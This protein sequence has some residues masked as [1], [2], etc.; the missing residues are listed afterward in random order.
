MRFL[1]G[2]VILA[3]LLASR[4][5]AAQQPPAAPTTIAVGDWQLAPTM[6]VRVRGEYR[7]DAPDLGGL[8]MYGRATP[9]TRDAWVVLERT[10]VGLGAERGALRAQVTLQD[11]R[12]FGSPSPNATLAGARGLG[13]LAPYEGFL[14]MRTSG[15]R[16]TYLRLGRQAVVWGEGRL[17]G[18]ADFSPV[19]RSL[20]AARA[21]VAAGNFDFEALAAILEIP[22]PLG[23]AFGDRSGS[24]T[25]G[26]QLYGVTVKWT[27]DPLFRVEAFGLARV[28]RSSGAE[29]DGSR[30][31]IQRAVGER[32]T[33]A[34]RVSGDDKGWSYGAEGAYQMGNA[35]TLR[36][37]GA[38]IAAWAAAAHVQ[39]TLE[40]IVLTP[41][42]R[43]NGS[44]ASGDD[45]SGK[46]TQFD[47]LLADPQRFH[48][49][50]DLF[51]WSN[52]FDLGGRA[53]VVPWTDTALS[54][55][56][57]YA[58][59]AKS[60][61]EW[62]GSYLTA[63]GSATRPPVVAI[64]PAPAGANVDPSLGHELDVGFSWRPWMP[65]EL[66]AS[67]SGLLLGDGAK[68][69]MASHQRGS[70]NLAQYAFL[71]ATLNVP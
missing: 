34:L 61:G 23:A 52:M 60:R 38:D 5:A 70:H 43:L 19:G 4:T 67:W 47:P 9:R 33:G 36:F 3:G 46:Y 44:Y 71:Q 37:N 50:M 48:G 6:E 66:R 54:F 2:S 40:Q 1:A 10:R 20:D 15:V 26:V 31:A 69:I 62:I 28:A 24:N 58:Q 14:E 57:R 13:Q 25:S 35:D 30:F 29:L 32:Y 63:V 49:M 11:A 12:A 8:D 21:H 55:E 22:Q 68:A 18:N 53:T 17:V 51:A 39:K 64:T 27:V 41:T 42:F 65:L 56:Y 16:P 7:H 59:L 45:G